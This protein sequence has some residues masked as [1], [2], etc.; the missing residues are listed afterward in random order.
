[1]KYFCTFPDKSKI[2][3]VA[4]D[5]I[6]FNGVLQTCIKYTSELGLTSTVCVPSEWISWSN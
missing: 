4:S 2:E 5:G 6:R 1:M 3:V